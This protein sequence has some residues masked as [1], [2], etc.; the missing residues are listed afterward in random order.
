MI[1][2]GGMSSDITAIKIQMLP[3]LKAAGVRRAA[4]FGS[5]ARGEATEVS[6]VDILVELPDTASLFDL[7]GLEL[8]L[9]EKLGKK[10]DV[11]TYR[12]L[13]PRL[14]DSILHDAIPIL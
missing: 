7:V 8:D 12:A 9:K 14:K 3:I 13:H 5:T 10:V 6:D 11:V 2:V 4:I 1:A